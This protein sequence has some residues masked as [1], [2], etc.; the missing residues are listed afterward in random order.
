MYIYLG[1][2]SISVFLL[3]ISEKCKTIKQKDIIS[4]LGL[5]IPC[6]LAGF[7]AD[8]IGTDVN[9]YVKPVFNAARSSNNIF[10]YFQ[11]GWYW[12]W[13]YKYVYEHELGFTLM[14]YILTKIFNSLAI[15]LFAIEA[16]IISFIYA[17]LKENKKK[18]YVWIGMLTFYFM[19][20]NNTLNMM[21]QW[22]AMSVLFWAF[23][24][25]K[26]RQ[27][28][29]FIIANIFAL[30]FHMSSIIGIVILILYRYINN[31]ETI[32]RKKIY[33]K[34]RKAFIRIL[35]VTGFAL[36]ALLFAGTIGQILDFIGLHRFAIYVNGSIHLLPNQF[37][38]RAPFVVIVCY[39][40]RGIVRKEPNSYFFL[41]M[42]LLDMV[43]SQLISITS[44]A[45]RIPY[46]F[47]EYFI[48]LCPVMWNTLRKKPNRVWV[49]LS[50][51]AYLV[52]YW[53]FF[54][55][56]KGSSETVPY[57]WRLGGGL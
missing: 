53:W 17:G 29:R 33:K 48:Y 50:L 34:K 45:I 19:F 35:T 3:Y 5:L 31:S 16:F 14:V 24:Y 54:Y 23:K 49:H 37:L 44:Y 2:F 12:I 20:Y 7:R 27:W 42:L 41:S 52:I 47:S 9:V 18:N 8:I 56:F 30:C 26:N 13:H 22:M 43:M 25:L 10:E 46:F 38:I 11:S 1:C 40:W 57:I 39:L 4:F 51:V 6:L 36:V 32:K 21:R 15:V 55:V 28:K